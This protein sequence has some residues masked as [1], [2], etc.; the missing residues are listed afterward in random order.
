M[1]A[2][3]TRNVFAFGATALSIE[4]YN[5]GNWGAPGAEEV[6]YGASLVQNIDDVNM[7]IYATDRTFDNYTNED[8]PNED[9]LTSD[10]FA[11]GLRWTF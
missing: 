7:Q 3:L 5:N 6:T 9:F 8:I 1:K 10:A 11:I 4:Y 2:G